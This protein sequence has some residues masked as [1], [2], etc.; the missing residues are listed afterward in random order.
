M[1]PFRH[2]A[3]CQSSQRSTPRGGDRRSRCSPRPPARSAAPSG[4]WLP[5]RARPAPAI[6]SSGS[7]PRSLSI[8]IAAFRPGT[9]VTEPPD[10]RRAARLVEA[11]DRHAVIAPSPGT[12]RFLPAER[13]AAV[14]AV[15]R[16]ADHV[17]VRALD[18]LRALHVRGEDVL[19]RERRD[20]AA[21]VLELAPENRLLVLLPARDALRQ[22]PGLRAQQLDRVMA[23]GRAVRVD[24]RRR[25]HEQP[26]HALVERAR[27]RGRRARARAR[28]PASRPSRPRRRTAR[29]VRRLELRRRVGGQVARHTRH[30]DVVGVDAVDELLAPRFARRHLDEV[31][32]VDRRQH[33]APRQYSARRRRSRHRCSAR[34]RARGETPAGCR[35]RSSRGPRG[36]A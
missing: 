4:Q 8:T 17:R 21:H 34:P 5:A 7:C 27:R 2:Q 22:L 10:A 26:R 30:A 20:E 13:V 28:P 19:V 16:T 1:S 14:S 36:S 11:R 9:P 35:A 15:E 23:L 6:T 31:L 24:E 12:G 3:A 18:V 33:G 25:G 29:A 32:D